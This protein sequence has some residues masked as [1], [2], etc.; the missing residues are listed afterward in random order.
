MTLQTLNAGRPAAHAL[1]LPI[2]LASGRR[3]AAEQGPGWLAAARWL[4]GYLAAY[5][6][7]GL[8]LMV[9][10]MLWLSVM[11][12]PTAQPALGQVVAGQPQ[13]LTALAFYALYA[14]GLLAFALMPQ[15]DGRAVR[16]TVLL[17]A[18]FGFFAYALV[19]LAK[20]TTLV[21]WSFGLTLVD[22]AWGT[23]LSALSAGAGKTVLNWAQKA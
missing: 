10:D 11:V 3:W 2:G 4:A 18:V 15:A 19:D 9:L 20:H 7:V 13:P 23:L 6:V 22:M 1:A 12:A 17:G 16:R 21:H 14:A 5:L 8:M